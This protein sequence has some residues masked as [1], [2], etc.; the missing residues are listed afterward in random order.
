MI[1]LKGRKL[2][3]GSEWRVASGGWRGKVLGGQGERRPIRRWGLS[4]P[5]ILSSISCAAAVG[6]GLVHFMMVTGWPLAWAGP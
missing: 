2:V 3:A 6:S 1:R 5:Y 4:V